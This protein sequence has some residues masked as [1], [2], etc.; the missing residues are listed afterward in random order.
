MRLVPDPP[1]CPH[2]GTDLREQVIAELRAD[3]EV[4]VNAFART[5]A[6]GRRGARPYLVIVT[7]PGAGHEEHEVDVQGSWEP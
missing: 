2:D 3:P 6:G 5:R 4:V 7:C 1:T